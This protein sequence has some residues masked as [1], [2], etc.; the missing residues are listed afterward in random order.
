MRSPK[1]VAMLGVFSV[2][3]GI[4]L[5][6]FNPE[7]SIAQGIIGADELNFIN[8]IGI[9]VIFIGFYFVLVLLPAPT[10]KKKE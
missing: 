8:F 7:T 2:I 6:I 9:V 10:I 1:I 3:A 5:S 4:G